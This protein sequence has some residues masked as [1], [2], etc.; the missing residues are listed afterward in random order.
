MSYFQNRLIEVYL[1]ISL[2][3]R[4][5][6]PM[7]SPGCDVTLTLFNMT[8][9][10]ELLSHFTTTEKSFS[11]TPDYFWKIYSRSL[12]MRMVSGTNLSGLT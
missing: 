10:A 6:L 11:A 7:L 1:S 12:T 5:A 8:F 4:H 2:A 9:A 3:I